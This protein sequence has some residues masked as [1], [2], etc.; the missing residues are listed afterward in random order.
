MFTNRRN[1]VRRGAFEQ[2]EVGKSDGVAAAQ[3]CELQ[4]S[5]IGQQKLQFDGHILC[6]LFRERSA[7][8]RDPR[9]FPLLFTSGSGKIRRRTDSLIISL[10]RA[11]LISMRI[12]TNTK[13]Y[14]VPKAKEK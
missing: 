3:N 12:E 4:E 2:A 9:P 7:H 11:H 10:G 13:T 5:S 8:S 6:S 14:K 1:A